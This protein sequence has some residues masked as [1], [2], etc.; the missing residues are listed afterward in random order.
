MS[1]VLD[2]SITIAWAYNDETTPQVLDVFDRLIANGAW[3]PSLWRIEVANVLEMK[4][5]G[6]RNDAVFRDN[7]LTN[8]SLLPISIDQETDRQ[9]W[10]ATLRLAERH[11]LTLYDAVYLELALRRGIPLATLDIELRA[12]AKAEGV[13]LLGV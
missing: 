6:R 4:V 2:S 10:G 7:A 12:A 11:R 9:A 13:G 1:L 8:L 3:V 5:R